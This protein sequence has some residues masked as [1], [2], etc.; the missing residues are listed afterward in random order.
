MGRSGKISMGLSP[1]NSLDAPKA[2]QLAQSLKPYIQFQSTLSWLK[3][4]PATYAD[5]LFDPVD[6]I[7]GLDQNRGK[8]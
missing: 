2:V 5:K 8:Y 6:L 4:P 7:G 3:S 1:I